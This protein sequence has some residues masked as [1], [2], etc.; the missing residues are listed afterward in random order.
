MPSTHV[1]YEAKQIFSLTLTYGPI[2]R[3]NQNSFFGT[4]NQ[5]R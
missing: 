2:P 1:Q 3:N 5:E 4:E